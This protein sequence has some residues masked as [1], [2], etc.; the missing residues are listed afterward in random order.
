MLTNRFFSKIKNEVLT[1]Y[2]EGHNGRINEQI[3]AVKR[4]QLSEEKKN[5]EVDT[6]GK[7]RSGSSSITSI[8]SR[9]RL[10]K[11]EK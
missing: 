5:E 3:E 7:K 1:T 8:S 2:V 4:S 6:L 9:L 10:E 11:R